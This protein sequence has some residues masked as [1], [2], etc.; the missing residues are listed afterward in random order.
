MAKKGKP[1][2]VLDLKRFEIADKY[3][4]GMALLSGV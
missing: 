2:I 1:V 4:M 3:Q